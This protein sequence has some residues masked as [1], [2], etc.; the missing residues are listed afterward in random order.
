MSIV[1]F[2]N[3][4]ADQEAPEPLP[5]GTY[6]AQIVGAE[7]KVSN[8]G[9]KY[10]AVNFRIDVNDYPADFGVENAPDGVNIIY[11]RAGME[12]TP[13]SRFGLKRF[14]TAIGA[15]MSSRINVEEWVGL[16]ASVEVENDEWEGVERANIVKVEAA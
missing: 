1:E 12:D 4:I 9:N 7:V 10:A 8:A 5:A 15:E 3:N 16:E 2:S 13:G 14:C 11:R 6:P